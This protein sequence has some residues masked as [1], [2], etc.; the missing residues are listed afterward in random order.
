MQ[1]RGWW[2]CLGAALV[3]TLAAG[4]GGSSG[5]SQP[6]PPPPNPLYV[7]STGRDTNTGA[8][9]ANALRTIG[10]AAQLARTGYEIIV[11]PGTYPGN[12]GTTAAVGPAPQRVQFIADVRGAQ[13]GDLPGEVRVV[14]DGTGAGFNISNSPG[15]LIDGFTIVGFSDA[16]IVIKSGSNNFTIQN[17]LI[18]SNSGN[19]I[20]VQDSDDVLIFNNLVHDNDKT[21]IVVA[22][23]GS[24]SRRARVLSNTIAQNGAQGMP[25]ERGLTIGTSSTASPNAEV[26]NN[27]IQDNLGSHSIKVFSTPPRSDEGYNA[28]NPE[29][30]NLVF[31]G[32]YDPSHIRG[33]SDLNVSALY[34]TAFYLTPNSPA[35]DR[36]A[37]LNLPNAQTTILR[38]RTTTGTDLDRGAFD[39][40]FHFLPR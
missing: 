14:G 35:I 9:P 34:T 6:G 18:F 1:Y 4:C 36:G 23:N 5:D 2:Q 38:S 31:P 7:R 15:T 40:G 16:G 12:I 10:R 3:A 29:G 37:G 30:N 17:C 21:G 25:S 39:L 27:I 28:G 24:G 8:D 32:T 22:G 19:G 11:G 20:R 33:T 13:T 26:R